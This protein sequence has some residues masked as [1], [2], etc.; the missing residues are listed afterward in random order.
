[1]ADKTT[2]LLLTD[3]AEI[4]SQVS[5]KMSNPTDIM[6]QQSQD[7]EEKVNDNGGSG[8]SD[9]GTVVVTGASGFVASWTITYL[10]EKG[11]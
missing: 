2:P 4:G 5:S 3:T 11:Y 9:K 7:E 8:S 10:C 1:M 6:Q